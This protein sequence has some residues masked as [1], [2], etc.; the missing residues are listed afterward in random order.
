[1]ESLLVNTANTS[2]MKLEANGMSEIR[3]MFSSLFKQNHEA[4]EDFIMLFEKHNKIPI[5]CIEIFAHIINVHELWLNRITNVEDGEVK[6]WR[7]LSK[8]DFSTHNADNYYITLGLLAS[9][10]YGKIYNWN[11]SYTNQDGKQ[12]ERSLTDAYIHIISHST[13]HRGQLAY[14]LKQHGIS[15]PEKQFSILRNNQY[16]F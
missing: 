12:I 2:S 7:S 16:P 10:S 13:Y 15:L 8:E 1:M 5:K 4:N 11:F 9:E 14:I 3:I 6:A